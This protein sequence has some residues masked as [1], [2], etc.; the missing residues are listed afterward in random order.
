MATAVPPTSDRR[1]TGLDIQQLEDDETGATAFDHFLAEG[2]ITDVVR[3][4]KTGKEAWPTVRP[5]ERTSS[6]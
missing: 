2:L 6:R 3:I 1:E 4:V 5:P